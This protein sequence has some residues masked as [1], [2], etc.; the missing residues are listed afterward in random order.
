M[1]KANSKTQERFGMNDKKRE[2]VDFVKENVE[3]VLEVS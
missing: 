2:K 3:K 1:H